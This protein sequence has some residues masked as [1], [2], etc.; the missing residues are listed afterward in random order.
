LYVVLSVL[1]FYFGKLTDAAND[2]IDPASLEPFQSPQGA[3]ERSS[4]LRLSIFGGALIMTV[5]DA[6]SARAGAEE[7]D[8]DD[9]PQLPGA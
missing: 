3:Y 8:D 1:Q 9:F 4:D 6:T 5:A 2:C 7:A